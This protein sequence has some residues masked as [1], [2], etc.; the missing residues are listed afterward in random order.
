[1]PRKTLTIGD[2]K[3]GLNNIKSER[4]IDPG[5]SPNSSNVNVEDEGRLKL[6]G[7]AKAIYK[8]FNDAITVTT[9]GS[10]FFAFSHDYDMV[11][12][13]SFKTPALGQT[14]Y[15][16]KESADESSG[17]DLAIYDYRNQS[18]HMTAVELDGSSGW[19]LD[20]A[21]I[22]GVL[23]IS[24]KFNTSSEVKW[25]GVINRSM[26]SSA[27]T[28]NKWHSGNAKILPP[29]ALSSNVN[30]TDFT[31][32]GTY[33]GLVY[34]RKFVGINVDNV[35]IWDTRGEVEQDGVLFHFAWIDNDSS[36]TTAGDDSS[37]W[38]SSDT[39]TLY[40]SSIYDNGIQESEPIKVG[41]MG[42][43][44]GVSQS[45]KLFVGITV[46][47]WSSTTTSG[48]MYN[49]SNRLTGMKFYIHTEG[50]PYGDQHLLMVVDFRDGC[51][52]SE[53]RQVEKWGL[54]Y[55]SG[56]GVANAF[57]S[58]DTAGK[59]IEFN[60]PPIAATYSDANGHFS[61]E[62]T[63][64]SWKASCNFA[65]RLFIGN[66]TQDGHTMGDTILYSPQ[67]QYDKYPESN[68]LTI[69]INDGDEIIA[70]HEFGSRI[71]LFKS[72]TLYTIDI[73]E[74]FSAT[75][76]KHPFKGVERSYQICK[77][78]Q[79]V[80]WVNK[81]GLFWYDGEK[82]INLM[83]GKLRRV[84]G[85]FA[86]NNAWNWTGYES[87]GYDEPTNKL[88]IMKNV[89]ANGTNSDDIWVY[90]LRLNAWGTINN[91]V[92]GSSQK[93]NWINAPDGNLVYTVSGAHTNT[94]LSMAA[95]KATYEFKASMTVEV[96]YNRAVEEYGGNLYNG[97]NIYP[98]PVKADGDTLSFSVN[99]E[100]PPLDEGYDNGARFR[101]SGSDIDNI[102][103]NSTFSIPDGATQTSKSTEIRGV[104]ASD[105]ETVLDLFSAQNWSASLNSEHWVASVGFPFVGSANKS[106]TAGFLAWLAKIDKGYSF[107]HS[108]GDSWSY[109]V[110]PSSTE[111]QWELIVDS[112]GTNNYPQF[113]LKVIEGLTGYPASTGIL[114]LSR[115]NIL[116]W[117]NTP[118]DT[119]EFKYQTK[120]IDFGNQ[121]TRKNIKRVDVTFKSKTGGGAAADSNV[122]VEVQATGKDGIQTYGFKDSKSY[123]YSTSKGLYSETTSDEIDV[124]NSIVAKLVP[125]KSIKNVYSCSIIFS[126]LS[127]ASVV[128]GFEIEDITIVYKEKNA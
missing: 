117:D 17:S 32:S 24:D 103:V 41:S 76:A 119:S 96:D 54:A 46:K 111:T 97:Q 61:D 82:I 26:F 108:A 87:I 116:K 62:K 79:G 78:P 12:S 110:N 5:E 75:S 21:L 89:T 101:I 29:Y 65:N 47:P 40:A 71:L 42:S 107:R 124:T 86:Y 27:F 30:G 51:R 73:A 81:Y 122:K 10:G 127:S 126:A 2:F 112:W 52:K 31:A 72:R 23:R 4:D 80:Y 115:G 1:M 94:T 92:N 102:D 43:P 9:A 68:K 58:P 85:T 57:R 16:I 100:G 6:A 63:K 14:D 90:D 67:R 44:A 15:L 28:I 91:A 105:I 11:S 70:M 128:A 19:D 56:S 53:S 36:S 99:P 55:N 20:Y 113:T 88:L 114:T 3:G 34:L 37:T 48:D 25:L 13:G 22:D 59:R 83:E 33:S 74:D 118:S 64:A 38:T 35:S 121:A 50:D 104:S 123:N 93:T 69:A 7:S 49:L 109:P 77:T 45:S 98:V 95:Y 60:D 84:Q 120:E 18:W 39:Y 8:E 125:E 106:G 66:V